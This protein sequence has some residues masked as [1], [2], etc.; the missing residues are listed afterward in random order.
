M[1]AGKPVQIEILTDGKPGHENQSLGLAEAI[2]R[3]LPV[4]ITLRPIKERN[5]ISSIFKKDTAPRPDLVIGAGHGVHHHLLQRSRQAGVPSVV[6]MKPSLP[7][8][9]FTVVLVPEHDF[10]GK[11]VPAG[12][13]TT[14]GALNRVSPPGDQP[15]SGGLFLIGG[16]SAAHGW[17]GTATLD[18]IG[19]IVSGHGEWK[20][21]DSRRTP[22]GFIDE[23][24]AQNPSVQ[25]FPH[26]ET[27]RDWL[28]AQLA[29][30]AEVWVTEDSASMVYEA[31]TSGAR[32]GLLAVPR[33]KRS[34][35]AA[36]IDQ[37]VEK[38]Y[39]THFKDWQPG[40]ELPSPPEILREADRCAELVMKK[41][42]WR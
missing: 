28:P 6:L 14:K 16:E 2:G 7:L 19:R 13:I 4:E 40:Q 32:V 3:R 1:R 37:L 20:L 8:S 24:R 30:A 41:L 25:V 11:P 29:A 10:I 42:G 17:D 35:V 18:A 38:G 23:L 12:I 26:Q 27:K 22:P 39:I 31:L 34:R 36:G 15:R 33:K 9:L 5:L 21:T